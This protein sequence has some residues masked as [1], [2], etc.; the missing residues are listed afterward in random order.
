MKLG[1]DN[2][3]DRCL[4]D[5]MR[6]LD[7]YDQH[8]AALNDYIDM[9]KQRLLANREFAG[10]TFSDFSQFVIEFEVHG[11]YPLDGLMKFV[12]NHEPNAANTNAQLLTMHQAFLKTALDDFIES[13]MPDIKSAYEDLCKKAA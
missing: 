10:L 6:H 4:N 13:R 12:I 3:L 7:E 1:F 11:Q 8:Q 9:G 2:H 5:D